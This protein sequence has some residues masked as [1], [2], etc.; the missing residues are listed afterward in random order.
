MPHL[1]Q[2]EA[3]GL[4]EAPDDY[5][6]EAELEGRLRAEAELAGL[7]LHSHSRGVSEW[8]R[9]AACRASYLLQVPPSSTY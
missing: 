2:Y 3:D 5:D 9:G 8:L 1:D 7:A 4:G 6:A